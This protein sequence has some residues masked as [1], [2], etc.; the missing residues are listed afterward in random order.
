[1]KCCEKKWSIIRCAVDCE[2]I[3]MLAASTAEDVMSVLYYYARKG[4]YR[5]MSSAAA[6][7]ASKLPSLH[8]CPFFQAVG[9][10]LEGAAVT[11]A[12]RALN[13]L[14]GR[15]ELALAVA[16][17]LLHAHSQSARSDADATS[18]LTKTIESEVGRAAS[19]S[20]VTAGYFLLMAGDYNQARIY[21]DKAMSSGGAAPAAAAA[22]EDDDFGFASSPTAP[23]APSGGDSSNFPATA[24]VLRAWIDVQ[25]GRE[26]YVAR[27]FQCISV[28]FL[29]L[30]A[31][32]KRMARQ[33]RCS[34]QRRL[35]HSRSRSLPR[36]I[37]PIPLQTRR[38]LFHPRRP[39]HHSRV[40][41]RHPYRARRPPL[42]QLRRG[43]CSH[44]TPLNLPVYCPGPHLPRWRPPRCLRL[45][46]ERP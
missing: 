18:K 11:D 27:F 36:C 10:L 26:S 12:I 29:Q 6:T 42:I 4:F 5:H 35:Q 31:Q 15:R 38:R 39:A 32:S 46:H 33:S 16:H 13:A 45:A 3:A 43:S 14:G 41:H 19:Q 34:T 40:V 24:A 30:C 17:A 28:T 7:Y 44:S 37:L 23:A 22:A 25:C 2:S 8:I 21:A 1:M 9:T 20:F